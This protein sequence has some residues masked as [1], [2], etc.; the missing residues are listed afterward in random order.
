M[1]S[2]LLEKSLED[3]FKTTLNF[4]MKHKIGKNIIYIYIKWIIIINT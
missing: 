1:F 3:N 2:I 4:F